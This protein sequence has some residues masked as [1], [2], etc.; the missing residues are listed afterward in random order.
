MPDAPAAK[1]GAGGTLTRI[2]RF[3]DLTLL[4]IG[5]MIGTGLFLTA[6]GVAA[7]LHSLAWILAAWALGGLFAL[8]GALTYAELG[9][10]FPRAGGHYAYV[11]ETYG[12]WAAFFDGWI[13]IVAAF[14]CGIAF[15][16]MGFAKYLSS[17]LSLPPTAMQPAAV[18]AVIA[19]TLINCI[20]LN[21][22]RRTQNL[23]TSLKIA[24]LLGIVAAGIWWGLRSPL[25]D[26]A[27]TAASGI[28][29]WWSALGT[30]MIGI[31]FAYLG[32]D[33]ATYV[34][35]ECANPQRDLPRAL[36]TGTLAVLAIYLLFN[37][38]LF[39]IDPG[40][41]PAIA[42][43]RVFGATGGALFTIV[44]IMCILGAM[45]ATIMVGPRVGYAMAGDGLLFSVMAG[46]NAR[47]RV[48]VRAIVL[49]G[50]WTVLILGT[51]TYSSIMTGAVVAMIALSI[52]T[53]AAVFI[54]RVRRP[55]FP[56]PYR[57]WGYP[58][59]PILYCV[60]TLAILVN[61][62]IATPRM[63]LWS[64]LVIAAGIPVLLVS[65]FLKSNTESRSDTTRR[66]PS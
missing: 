5:N 12:D 53:T 33:A 50:A 20:G 56:R 48:P 34:A 63:I 36:F 9:A 18:A 23:L 42:L 32:W 6:A 14:P 4:V 22:G 64:A 28:V 29:S 24:G 17:A 7:N 3:P 25:A 66:V 8:A 43:N 39:I 47:A 40:C 2:L 1:G 37:F 58:V 57:T 44:I 41:D 30:A 19:L 65:R 54:L 62:M 55:D 11:R 10:M 52:L 26:P 51:G 49:Q 16:A 31:S 46:V 27:V 61:T 59:V 45:N 15:M 38:A 13:S 60:G 35:A 21:A